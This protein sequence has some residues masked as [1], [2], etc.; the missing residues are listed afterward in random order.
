LEGRETFLFNVLF[1]NPKLGNI[2]EGKEKN[3][4][5]SLTHLV[6]NTFNNIKVGLSFS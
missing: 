3:N 2:G 4:Y 6:I 1:P 5:K